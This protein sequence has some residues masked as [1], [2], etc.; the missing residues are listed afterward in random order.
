MRADRPDLIEAYLSELRAKLRA[1][2]AE[3][4]LA[5]A[6]D[7][8][9]ESVA[10]GVAIGMSERKRRR[11]PFRRSVRCGPSCGRTR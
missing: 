10:A 3:L 4:V 11:R 7:H 5:E 8:L 9:R 6:E 1:P 2:D